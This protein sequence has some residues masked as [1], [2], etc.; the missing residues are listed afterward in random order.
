MEGESSS[1]TIEEDVFVASINAKS[2][3]SVNL[4]VLLNP[5]D[6]I[7]PE[8]D[9]SKK[10]IILRRNPKENLGTKESTT[11]VIITNEN[12]KTSPEIVQIEK[13][14]TSTPNI[15]QMTKQKRK[16]MKLIERQLAE[17][18]GTEVLEDFDN[19]DE[20]EVMK[21]RVVRKRGRPKGSVR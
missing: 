10:P 1:K 13:F 5:K 20:E 14:S 19:E 2:G 4:E 18:E 8:T 17:M 11:P 7:P 6:V 9:T 15:V 12:I 21:E 3:A 16:D